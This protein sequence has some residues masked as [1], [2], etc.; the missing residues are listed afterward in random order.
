[1]A[2]HREVEVK[3]LEVD[4]QAVQAR[5]IDLGAIKVFDDVLVART[6]KPLPA[7]VGV[8]R[9]RKEGAKS[10]LVVKADFSAAAVARDSVEREV[11][12]GDFDA[13]CDLLFALGYEEKRLFS[14]HRTS[15]VLDGVRFEFDKL[16][17]QYAFVPEFLELE[18]TSES[19]VLHAAQRVGFSKDE[20]V[21]WSNGQ[22][23][24]HYQRLQK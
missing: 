8:L 23:I 5:L 11:Q 1:M 20:L 2:T 10:F 4:R 14:K 12:V 15:Y 16:L 21:S 7:G 18:A 6:F 3:V 19:A 24:R 22:V 17:D 9:V 13:A